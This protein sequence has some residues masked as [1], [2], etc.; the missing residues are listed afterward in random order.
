METLTYN[1]GETPN[2]VIRERAEWIERTDPTFV[3]VG[4]D[5]SVDDLLTVLDALAEPPMSV[6]AL[7][8][9]AV[10]TQRRDLRISILSALGIE[11]A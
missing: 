10:A 3:I 2:A 1:Y 11:E 5:R 6:A 9:P 8:R 7:M 4:G